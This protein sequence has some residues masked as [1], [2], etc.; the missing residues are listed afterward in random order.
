[1]LISVVPYKGVA[2]RV[3][4][5]CVRRQDSKWSQDPFSL[6]KGKLTLAPYLLVFLSLMKA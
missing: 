6:R 4:S 5:E 2:S 1:M 3:T